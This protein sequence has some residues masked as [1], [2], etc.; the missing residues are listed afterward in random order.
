M[1]DRLAVYCART[2]YC[3][4]AIA[5][6]KEI[7]IIATIAKNCIIA[8]SAF[9]SFIKYGSNEDVISRRSSVTCQIKNLVLI[10]GR[11]VI[12]NQ[13]CHTITVVV[14]MQSDL[15]DRARESDNQVILVRHT[16]CKC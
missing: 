10:D 5:L 12:K 6:I 8:L 11:T 9:E 2:L 1:N 15:I 3:V 16:P 7:N 14:I 13:L 4:L